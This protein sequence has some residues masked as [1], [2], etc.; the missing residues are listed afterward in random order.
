MKKPINQT[1]GIRARWAINTLLPVVAILITLGAVLS[2][3]VSNYYRGIMLSRVISN[4]ETTADFFNRYLVSA[5]DFYTAARSFTNEFSDKDYIEMQTVSAGGDI[6]YSSSGIV[7]GYP[8]GTPDVSAC[9]VSRTLKTYT[10]ADSLTGERVISVSTPLYDS[11]GRLSG[12]FR[13]VTSMERADRAIGRFILLIVLIDAAILLLILWTNLYF[14]RSIVTP[15]RK[16]NEA[17][18][19]IAAGK[20]GET[21]TDTYNDEIGELAETIN[22]MSVEIDRSEKVKNDFISSVSHELR[23]P[24][25]AI[26]GWSET[27]ETSMDSPAIL[28]RGLSV[29]S[30]ESGNLKG[31]LDELLDFSRME[32][33]R[34]A[35]HFGQV[36]VSDE[37]EDVTFSFSATLAQDGF[38]IRYENK[39]GDDVWISADR[40]R[41]RQVFVILIDN[42]RK[43]AC[44]GKFLDL[45][46]TG[47]MFREGEPCVTVTFR[48]YGPGIPEADLPHVTEKFYKG[49]SKRPGNG[50]GLAVAKEIVTLHD[51]SLLIQN[52]EE[53]TGT[54]ITVKLPYT[55]ENPEEAKNHGA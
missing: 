8:P 31:M 6:I 45:T 12:Y 35:V 11:E 16:I 18:K 27:L 7:N 19:K 10:G 29:I 13:F 3:T 5:S 39:L 48:D 24:L 33:G 46:L 25:T 30:R 54:Q 53:G 34:L 20:Y 47:G 38:S 17:A 4:A 23:T 52:A 36:N 40:A 26:T 15:V 1:R 9:S 50:I 42:A 37:L 41:L 32:S 22:F 43:H 55:H 44:D 14:L 2:V 51:G 21:I 49:S 28:K